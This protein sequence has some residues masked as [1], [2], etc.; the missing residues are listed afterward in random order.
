M[1]ARRRFRYVAVPVV[2]LLLLIG[3]EQ[4][5]GQC[6]E[7]ASDGVDL[8]RKV[9]RRLDSRLPR[10]E[11]FAV[12]VGYRFARQAQSYQHL[13]QDFKVVVTWNDLSVGHDPDRCHHQR[14]IWVDVQVGIVGIE[15]DT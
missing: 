13:G 4:H 7:Q 9:S 3:N 8:D 14:H 1:P 10:E 6:V 15:G 2:E 12:E 5:L 11:M